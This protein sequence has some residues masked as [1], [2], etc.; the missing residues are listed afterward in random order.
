MPWPQHASFLRQKNFFDHLPQ[1]VLLVAADRNHGASL[2][3]ALMK[4]GAPGQE[5]MFVGGRARPENLPDQVKHAASVCFTADEYRQGEWVPNICVA[6]IAYCEGYT[7]TWMTTMITGVY[8]SNQSKRTQMEGRINRAN[9]ERLH[10]TY[11][12]AMAG[13]TEV[14][15]KY[16]RNAKNLESAL[17]NL[18]KM[19]N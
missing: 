2:V 6:P 11:I 17:A 14:M 12:T 16:Q 1:R 9:C 7:L 18:S 13:L 3:R 4:S 19:K 5:I 15:Y 8:P 10:R